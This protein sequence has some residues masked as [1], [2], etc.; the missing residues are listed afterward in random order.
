MGCKKHNGKYEP[1]GCMN[2]LEDA[3]KRAKYTK[4]VL[5][6][7]LRKAGMLFENERNKF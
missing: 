3:M 7:K 6:P 2:C 5:R 1:D 4:D